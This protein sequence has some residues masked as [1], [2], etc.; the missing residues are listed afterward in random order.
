MEST[1]SGAIAAALQRAGVK[2]VTCVPGAGGNEVFEDFKLISRQLVP[3]SFHEEPA[4]SIAHGA[5]I[6]GAR[7]AVLFKSHGLIKAG[8]SVTDSLYCCLTAGMLALVFSD[9]DGHSSDS[10]LDIGPFLQ[11]IGLPYQVADYSDIYNQVLRLL[12]LS[13]KMGLPQA[14]VVESSEVGAPTAIGGLAVAVE[15]TERENPRPVYRRDIASRVLCPFFARYQYSV[16]ECK[17]RGEDWHQISRPAAPQIPGSAP[18]RWQ[19]LVEAYSGL[20]RV[21]KQIRGPLVTGEPGVSS[22][23]ACEPYGCIDITTYL[24]GSI[25]LAIGAYLG[26]QREVWAVSGDFAFISAGHLALLEAWQRQIP[27]KVLVLDNGESATTGGQV[28]PENALETVLCGYR[29]F[30]SHIRHPE[31]NDE[32]E[33]VLKQAQSSPAIAIVVA[34]YRKR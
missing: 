14:M 17:Y 9:K 24:G 1:I 20:F 22:L 15:M 5:A 34:D 25:P 31:D 8:N 29:D 30:V 10:I 19:A 3:V 18:G 2:V 6:A 21:F 27:L 11:G 32:V 23:F 16:L 7:S 4:Y 13:E 33:A 12:D 26:G 28:V